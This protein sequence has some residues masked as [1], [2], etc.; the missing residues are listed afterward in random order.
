[1]RDSGLMKLV[2]FFVDRRASPLAKLLF[3]LA[4]IYVIS[5]IDLVPDLALVIGWLDDLAVALGATAS[6]LVAIRRYQTSAVSEDRAAVP[7]IV[8]AEGVEIR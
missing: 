1:M 5:P 7:R 6:L 8:E 3:V 2:R 4:M